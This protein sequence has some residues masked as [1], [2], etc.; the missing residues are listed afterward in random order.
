M[1]TPILIYDLDNIGTPGR[2]NI[3]T[4]P[5]E[6]NHF[7]N[8]NSI[9]MDRFDHEVSHVSDYS[10]RLF[11]MVRMALWILRAGPSFTLRILTMSAWFINRKA[12]PSIC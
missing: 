2:T 5:P 12:S 8:A 9:L 1:H 4:L 7:V 6:F 3:S 10:S 11:L